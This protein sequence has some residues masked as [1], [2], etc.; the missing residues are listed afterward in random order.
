MLVGGRLHS[1]HTSLAA[2]SPFLTINVSLKIQFHVFRSSL[3]SNHGSTIQ[4]I[5]SDFGVL[6]LA[7]ILTVH[8]TFFVPTMKFL[9]SLLKGVPIY[10]MPSSSCAISE[11]LTGVVVLSCGHGNELLMV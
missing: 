11:Y 3:P 8:R 10:F 2:L 7:Q 5:A 6:M 4:S 9:H 1:R